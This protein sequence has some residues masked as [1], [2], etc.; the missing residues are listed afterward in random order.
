MSDIQNAFCP[1]KDC[2]D[3][4]LSD[5]GN[6]AFRASMAKRNPKIFCIAEHAV[7]ALHQLDRQPSLSFICQM[8]KLSR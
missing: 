4:G 2:K 8:S 6:I 3:Y 1:N 5:Q 7:S